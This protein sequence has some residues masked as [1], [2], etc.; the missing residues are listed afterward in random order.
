MFFIELFHFDGSLLA[1][2][3]S[4]LRPHGLDVLRHVV[5]HGF[6]CTFLK[7]LLVFRF[8]LFDSIRRAGFVFRG[9]PAAAR[10]VRTG[11]AA[12]PARHQ[13]A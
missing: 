1:F 12:A 5:E 3:C 9:R 10:H 2:P 7:F 4:L 8:F 11:G 13:G 6:I